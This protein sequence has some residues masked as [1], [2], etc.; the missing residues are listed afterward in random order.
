MLDILYLPTYLPLSLLLAVISRYPVY[1][2]MVTCTVRRYGTGNEFPL[3]LVG[4]VGDIYL[5]IDPASSS[6]TTLTHLLK[7]HPFP[8]NMR[9]SKL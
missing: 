1:S 6:A 4:L 9:E 8:L 5:S 3:F 2:F 7:A